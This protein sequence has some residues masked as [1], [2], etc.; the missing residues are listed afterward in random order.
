[1]TPNIEG[2]QVTNGPSPTTSA[3]DRKA[4]AEGVRR[5]VRSAVANQEGIR[6]DL[7]VVLAGKALSSSNQ[8]PKTPGHNARASVGGNTRAAHETR[9]DEVP[10][11]GT[12]KNAGIGIATPNPAGAKEEK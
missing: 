5:N 4:A 2:G 1:M 8:V 11:R 7:A 12:G 6:P 9:S 10:V 3:I